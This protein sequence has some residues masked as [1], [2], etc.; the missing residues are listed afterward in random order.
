MTWP[1][2]S[3]RTKTKKSESP[4]SSE[5][6][7]A[8]KARRSV[9]R[10]GLGHSCA[11]G[12]HSKP[13]W[14]VRIL[15]RNRTTRVVTYRDEIEQRT[16]RAGPKRPCFFVSAID[17]VSVSLGYNDDLSDHCETF[18]KFCGLTAEPRQASRACR[19]SDHTRRTP[20]WPASQSS[21]PVVVSR[22][23]GSGLRVGSLTR[24]GSGRA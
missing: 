1:G 16:E 15:H 5:S 22:D 9:S 21:R 10:P 24:R 19:D 14:Y 2:R 6:S 13:S 23:K 4:N 17:V 12:D 7:L 18:L 3:C 11:M 20:L 8:W